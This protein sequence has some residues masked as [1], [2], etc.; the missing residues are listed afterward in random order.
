MRILVTRPEP[1]ASAWVADL[2]AQGLHACALPLIEIAAPADATPVVGLWQGLSTR[3]LLMF[4]SPAAVQWFFKLRPAGATWPPQTLAATPGPGTAHSLLEHGQTA[5]LQASQLISPPEQAAQFDSEHLWPLL[6]PLDWQ[7]QRV[8]IISGGDQQEAR[9]RDWL[10]QQ[11]R[12]RGA[13]VESIL[14]Y[15]RQPGNWTPDQQALA[16]QALDQPQAHIWLL[17]SS[18]AIDQ[19]VQHHL[20]ALHLPQPPNWCKL[21]AMVTHPKIAQHA[22]EL[23]IT[24]ILSARPTLDAVAKAL[25]SAQ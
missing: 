23:G 13:T 10:S 15:Q 11:W 3:R 7:G 16:R 8:S 4:V 2:Q 6:S 1:Q 17:S 22:Q 12:A 19:L 25:R 14:T 5:G 21:R 9:G 20:P 24:R 18:Q